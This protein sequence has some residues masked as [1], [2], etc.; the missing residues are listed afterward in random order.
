ML[1]MRPWS[2]SVMGAPLAVRMA[3]LVR[4]ALLRLLLLAMAVA[5]LR[6]AAL[7]VRLRA[8]VV[9]ILAALLL[10]WTA[11][12]LTLLRPRRLRRDLAARRNGEADGLLDRA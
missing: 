12:L 5:V 11:V 1:L 3:V 2:M 8:A 6:P 7:G 9:S 10:L 4:P